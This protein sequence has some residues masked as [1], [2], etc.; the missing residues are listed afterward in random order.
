MGRGGAYLMLLFLAGSIIASGIKNVCSISINPIFIFPIETLFMTVMFAAIL[1]YRYLN[2]ANR[3]LLLVFCCFM[4]FLSGFSNMQRAWQRNLSGNNESYKN[5]NLSKIKE[6]FLQKVS[7]IIEEP[8][9][10]AVAAAFT[11]GEKKYLGKEIKKSYQSS[12]AMHILALSGL[13]I[14]II[15]GIL[16][17]LLFFL[18]TCYFSR[19]LKFIICTIF[20]FGYAMVTGFSASVQR[21]AIMI[22]IWKALSISGR[23]SGRWDVLLLS[24]CIILLINPNELNNIGFQLS[25]AAVAGIIWLY[26]TLSAA[27]DLIKEYKIYKYLKPVWNTLCISLACQIT[28][29]PIAWHYFHNFSFY[30][31]ITNLIAVPIATVSLYLI[32]LSL[33]TGNIPVLGDI[34]ETMAQVSIHF[35]N[36]T[37]HYIG[38]D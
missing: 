33:L 22:T 30:F 23:K 2:Y 3:R 13:H 25:F 16:N 19:Q 5:Q 36:Y 7:Q 21:A 37:I 24:A 32:A 18:N 31:L 12:G 38:R 9:D 15:Y 10:F 11:A 28:T 35:L 17:T 6:C 29:A 4:I 34:F 1:Q 20:I 27:F 26:P 14:G 8:Q